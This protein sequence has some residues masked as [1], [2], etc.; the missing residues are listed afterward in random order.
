M[1]L[2]DVGVR[3]LHLEAIEQQGHLRLAE[4]RWSGRKQ[5][6]PAKAH[7]W[8]HTNRVNNV[9]MRR[10]IHNTRVRMHRQR[11]S[12]VVVAL[13]PC[14]VIAPTCVMGCRARTTSIDTKACA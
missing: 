14:I 11:A 4:Q 10:P 7:Q 3:G 13:K 5:R 1:N 2:V 12:R 8:V 9:A 6:P